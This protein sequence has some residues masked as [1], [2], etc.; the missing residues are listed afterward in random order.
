V[1]TVE[2]LV[3]DET[4]DF[5]FLEV[6]TRLQVEHPVTEE[7]TGVDLVRTQLRVAAGEAL[8]ITQDDVVS[9]GHAIEVRLCAEDPT[10]GFL[11][12]TGTLA[13]FEPAPWPPVRFESGVEV[14]SRVSVAF[15]PLLAKVIA[16]APTRLEA[17]ATLASALEGLH[18]GGV[19]T[20]RDFLVATL[21]HEGFL[22]GDTTTDFIARY[23]PAR[24]LVLDEDELAFASAAGALWLQGRHRHE[25]PVLA[26]APSGWRNARL[27]RESVTLRRQG[28]HVV[29]YRRRRD[30]AFDVGD[31]LARVR[32][33]SPSQIDL[34]LNGRRARV[35]VTADGDWLHV[36]TRRG[37]VTFEV[38][39]RFHVPGAD[40]V[41]GGL[42]APMPGLV[43]A[44]R[45]EA[46]QSVLAGET[47]VVL[48]AMKMEHIITAPHDG[49]VTDVFV[50]ASQQVDR[51]ATLLALEGA[52]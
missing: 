49:V 28:D 8:D 48:E 31:A 46:G 4:R 34:E 9:R 10:N 15:D 29:A 38:V 5:F 3:D 24:E 51:G 47:L 44:V 37:T 23:E 12:A 7:V 22:A 36:Q 13:A 32:A 40:E 50:S 14:G 25:A 42:V 20:N 52:S 26:F 41:H 1:G 19:V 35:R 16:H 33:W 18:L 17:A 43:L 39:A 21:R 27:P 6:N 45:V 11:P 30:G 2:F